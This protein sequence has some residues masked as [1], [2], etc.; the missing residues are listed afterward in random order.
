MLLTHFLKRLFP[1][2]PDWLLGGLFLVFILWLVV[3]PIEIIQYVIRQEFLPATYLGRI[4]K[5]LYLLGFWISI[6]FIP[7]EAYSSFNPSILRL[8][9]VLLGLLISSP[10]YFVIGA[11]LAIKRAVTITLGVLLLVVQI[12]FGF[13][14]LTML[15]YS[16]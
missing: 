14:V 16:G 11:L 7:P 2:S 10:V 3:L 15:F 6:D 5:S 9:V 4:V 12:L 1:N 13:Y 8:V